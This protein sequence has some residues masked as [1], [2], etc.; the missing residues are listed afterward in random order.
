MRAGRLFAMLVDVMK[1]A[2]K[3]SACI[4][5]LGPIAAFAVPAPPTAAPGPKTPEP[6][7]AKTTLTNAPRIKFQEMV[8]DFGKVK[9]NEPL[10]TDFIFTNTGASV[11]EISDVRP[12]CGC[13]TAGTWDKSVKPGDTG[14]IPIQF[15]PGNFSGS[16][17]KSVTVTCNDPVQTVQS[18]SIKATIWRPIEITPAYV[19]FMGVEGEMTNET[20]TAKIIN[21]LD[22]EISLEKVD[23]PN[24]RFKTELKTVKPGKEFDLLVTYLGAISNTLPQ[25]VIT[26]K[27]SSSNAPALTVTAYAMPQPALVATPAMVRIPSTITSEFKQP[28]NIRNNG[29][30]PVQLSDASVNADGVTVKTTEVQP[31]KVFNVELTFAPDFKQNGESAGKGEQLAFTVK[32]SNPGHPLIRVP[33]TRTATPAPSPLIARPVSQP[34]AAK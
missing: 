6:L 26:I 13:T 33:I 23:S 31:G 24:P 7:V 30:T 29:N 22:E 11:L 10:R 1:R 16:V 15:N 28:I 2:L 32:T 12:G 20:K 17:T 8:H 9:A 25:S 5:M 3:N 4:L 34:Q 19:Y 27:T 18:L 21:N 14:K